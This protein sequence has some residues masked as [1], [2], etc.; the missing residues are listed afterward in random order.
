MFETA[1]LDRTLSKEAF[2]ERVPELRYQLLKAQRELLQA[3]FPVLIL[4][5]GVDGAGK[6][7]TANLL[8]E[9]LDTRLLETHA[10]DQPT[11]ADAERPRFWRYWLRTPPRGKIGIYI[12]NWYTQPIVTQV[13]GRGSGKVLTRQLTEIRKFE[14]TLADDGALIIKFWFHL[15]KAQQK[16]RLTK[17]E[18]DSKTAW[19][20]TKEDW[21]RFKRYEEFRRVSELALRDTSTGEAPWIVVEGVDP[22]SRAA[23]VGEE[24]L[25]RIRE[26]L[27]RRGAA[28]P[29]EP[30]PDTHSSDPLTILDRID[31]SQS[32]EKRDYEPELERQQA[33]LNKLS[34]KLRRQ[35]KSAV[36]VFEGWDAAGKGGAIRRVIHALDA[37]QFR[38]I[39]IAA[40]SPEERAHHYLWRFWRDL[41]GPGRFTI[42][43]RSWYGR[44]LVERVEGF[45]TRA[46]WRRAYSEI[47][48]FERQLTH[49]GRTA[50]VKIWLH[51]SPEE[52]LRRFQ[53]REQTPYK[54]HK[55]GPDDYRNREKWSA[56]EAAADVMVSA[57]SS[58][59]APW[60]LI[61]AESKYVARLRA[62]EAISAAIEDILD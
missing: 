51:I 30:P 59:A 20:V 55:I 58:R 26:H 19:R 40:P 25:S 49:D 24:L 42:Y 52:Q 45:A 37:R 44:V 7:E 57:T 61:P 32:L 14:Q 15:S 12:G 18:S 60:T 2:N 62:I 22:R 17:L 5:N 36:V 29:P 54:A 10:F 48:E 9:W 23:R 33:R 50:L 21:R 56:Y 35:G 4:L 16:A 13:L 8:N 46:E 11:E 53:E 47:N 34:R 6:G 31:L 1:E 28:T 27:A 38:V 3:D 43:D 39:P 41:P